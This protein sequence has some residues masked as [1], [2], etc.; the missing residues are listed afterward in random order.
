MV[1]VLLRLQGIKVLSC[2]PFNRRAFK[3]NWQLY[4]IVSQP[5]FT[6]PGLNRVAVVTMVGNLS[7]TIKTLLDG[8]VIIEHV[9][10]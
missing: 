4:C 1:L 7:S 2:L 8:N 6:R 3:C 5:I 9:Y 10:D